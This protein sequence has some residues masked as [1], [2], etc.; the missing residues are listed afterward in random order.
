MKRLTAVIAAVAALGMA[1]PS[2]GGELTA[3]YA[4][5]I[6]LEGSIISLDQDLYRVAALIEWQGQLF[7]CNVFLGSELSRFTNNCY[8]YSPPE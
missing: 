7:G 4:E 1:T 6:W 8:Y 2:W 3:P 5:K